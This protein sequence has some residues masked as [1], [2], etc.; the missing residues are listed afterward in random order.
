M[1]RTADNLSE[2][3]ED[4]LETILLLYKGGAPVRLIDISKAHGVS[5]STVSDAL[6]SLGEHGYVIYEKYRPV[7]LTAKGR[8]V[9][10]CVLNRHKL[11]SFFLTRVLD[12][13]NSEA[14]EV[15]CRMEHAIGGNIAFRLAMFMGDFEAKKKMMN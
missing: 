9:A 8:E 10:E 13:P 1:K 5:K 7:I 11:L 4:Y 14:D 3:K 15:A 2:V 6:S 12:I